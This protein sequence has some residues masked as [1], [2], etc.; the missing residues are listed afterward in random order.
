MDFRSETPWTD[1]DISL[2]AEMYFAVPRPPTEVM[3]DRLGRSTKAIWSGVSKLGMSQPGAKLRTSSDTDA[4][5]WRSSS[6]PA[7]VTVSAISAKSP[8]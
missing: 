8:T 7:S 5:G 3:A 2:L 4:R 6:L 1:A